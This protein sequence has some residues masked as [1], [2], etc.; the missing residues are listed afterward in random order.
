MLQHEDSAEIG[1]LL[2]LTK[3]MDA[4]AFVDKIGDLVGIKVGLCW[5]IT[6]I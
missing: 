1:W 6:D 5:K 2:Y 3:E 4:G